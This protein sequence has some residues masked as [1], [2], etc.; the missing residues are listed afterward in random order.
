M[1]NPITHFE[2]P[3]DNIE[4]AKKFY[5][6]IF[7]WKIEKYDD[8]GEEYYFVMTTEVGDDEWTPKEPGAINGGLVKREMPDEPF[9]NYVTVDSID[10][11]CKLIEK[12]GGKIVMPK[13]EMG[14]WGWWAIFKDTEGNV[15]GLYE[16]AK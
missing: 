16:E 6:K 2:I 9:I 4:R 5:E 8:K 12:N 10:R 3:A 7:D 11:T 15:L 13:T 1:K 14:E